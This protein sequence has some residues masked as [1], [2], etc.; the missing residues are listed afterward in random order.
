MNNGG[1]LW[2]IL[3]HDDGEVGLANSSE[4]LSRIPATVSQCG[5]DICDRRS[6]EIDRLLS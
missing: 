2:L 3:I 4:A 1:T 6:A 5:R